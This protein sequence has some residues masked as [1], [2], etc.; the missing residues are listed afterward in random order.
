MKIA[1]LEKEIASYFFIMS[2]NFFSFLRFHLCVDNF[3]SFCADGGDLVTHLF[4]RMKIGEIGVPLLTV[5]Q[6]PS[7]ILKQKRLL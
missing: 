5:R 3:T 1:L 2:L 6:T 4:W 7:S